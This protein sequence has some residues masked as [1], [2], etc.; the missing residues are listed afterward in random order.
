MFRLRAAAVRDVSHLRVVDSDAAAAYRSLE[1]AIWIGCDFD[2]PSDVRARTHAV[3]H[4]YRRAL[5]E[6]Y[7]EPSPIAWAAF[8]QSAALLLFALD[9]HRERFADSRGRHAALT[10][11]RIVLE[12]ADLIANSSLVEAS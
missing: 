10:L 6:S 9:Q 3:L 2:M 4:A 8:V 1:Q 7:A 11:R 12:N 5:D